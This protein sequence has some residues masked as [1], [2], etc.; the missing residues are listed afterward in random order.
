MIAPVS[1]GSGELSSSPQLSR[2]A[3]GESWE[4]PLSCYL[5]I[6][7]RYSANCGGAVIANAVLVLLLSP[8]AEAT[9]V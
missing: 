5:R 1:Y 7:G 2:I 9:S 3:T 8:A 6:A 4:G